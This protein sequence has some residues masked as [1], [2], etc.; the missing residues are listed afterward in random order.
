MRYRLLWW[1]AVILWCAAIYLFTASPV[2][3][4]S[5][6]QAIIEHATS[7]SSSAAVTANVIIRKSAHVLVFGL[8][9]VLVAMALRGVR[10]SLFIAWLFAACYG[11]L[12]EFH[13]SF[14]PG[15][16]AAATDAAIDAAGALLAMML[17]GLYAKWRRRRKTT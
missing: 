4:G 15:R 3:T 11:A 8:L 1:I 14:V 9:S 12:D 17:F 16:A 2:S 10:G 7:A 6:T 13:Q 5:H